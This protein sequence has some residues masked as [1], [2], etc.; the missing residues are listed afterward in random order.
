MAIKYE[1]VRGETVY[2]ANLCSI[3]DVPAGQRIGFRGPKPCDAHNCESRPSARPSPPCAQSWETSLSETLPS[4][5]NLAV[6]F[7]DNRFPDITF[8]SPKPP[9]YEVVPAP[10]EP[11]ERGD[12]AESIAATP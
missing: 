5:R 2:E 9:A 12:S 3:G 1:N 7:G 4:S 10:A 6:A 8:P 11:P